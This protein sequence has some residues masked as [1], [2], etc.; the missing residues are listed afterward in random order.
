MLLD[1]G[2]PETD[3]LEAQS[4]IARSGHG[5]LGVALTAL[6]QGATAFL[7]R[8]LSRVDRKQALRFAYLQLKELMPKATPIGGR[9]R[10]TFALHGA[11]SA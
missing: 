5:D 4:V 7:E 2:M 6:E 11:S 9:D 1:L 3:G 8:P 10:S